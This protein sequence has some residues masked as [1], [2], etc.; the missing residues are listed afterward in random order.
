LITSAFIIVFGCG[1]DKSEKPAIT[2]FKSSEEAA[3]YLSGN[4][5]GRVAMVGSS[6]LAKE[7]AIEQEFPEGETSPNKEMSPKIVKNFMEK[8]LQPLIKGSPRIVQKQF[9]IEDAFLGACPEGPRC[10]E[11]KVERFNC[12]S[13]HQSES[14]DG[15]ET[16]KFWLTLDV[17]VSNC[18]EEFDEGDYVITNGYFKAKIEFSA[19]RQIRS[20]QG[21]TPTQ[22]EIRKYKFKTEI[23]G[24][25]TTSES[26]G[27]MHSK[28]RIRPSQFKIEGDAETFTNLEKSTEKTISTWL[29]SGKLL[30][31]DLIANKREEYSFQDFKVKQEEKW[32]F[33]NEF[34]SSEGDIKIISGSQPPE[35][36]SPPE[37]KMEISGVYSVE[38]SPDSCIEGIFQYETVEPLKPSYDESACPVASGKIKVNNSILEFSQDKVIVSVD[39]ER[40]IYSCEEFFNLCQYESIITECGAASISGG[41]INL[42]LLLIISAFIFFVTR[43]KFVRFSERKK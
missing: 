33:A 25:L 34:S 24:D 29:I 5:G 2:K 31:E 1:G 35:Q 7:I 11:G 13:G 36:I 19:T 6:S 22:P 43:G 16:L 21:E 28:I 32:I 42:I 40:K 12:Q 14:K 39:G 20:K 27:T 26:H 23:D 3:K 38:T 17:A 8:T 10:V 30:A 9:D 37:M 4:M 15:Q 41:V 18:K